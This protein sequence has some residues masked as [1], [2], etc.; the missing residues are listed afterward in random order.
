MDRL[1][2][3]HLQISGETNI[4]L[5]TQRALRVH[6]PLKALQGWHDYFT[7]VGQIPNTS[8]VNLDL[9]PQDDSDKAQHMS[10]LLSLAAES[11]TSVLTI[12]AGAE[13]SIPDLETREE[14]TI[15]IV[16]AT[17]YEFQTLRMNEEFLHLLPALKRVIVGYFGPDVPT[18][19]AETELVHHDCCPDC[20]ENR[21]SRE[22]FF[23][24]GLYHDSNKSGVAVQHP[25]DLLVALHPGFE[26]VESE[27]WRPTLDSILDSGVPTV[28]TT[29]NHQEAMLEMTIL[30][31]MG[32]HVV[33]GMEKNKWSGKVPY[34]ECFGSRYEF[35]YT[36]H[37]CLL[38]L[39][40][41]RMMQL[42]ILMVFSSSICVEETSVVLLSRHEA[43]THPSGPPILA[44]YG[45][46]ALIDPRLGGTGPFSSSS[47]LSTTSTSETSQSSFV[48]PPE[49]PQRLE[50]LAT[51][52]IDKTSDSDALTMLN[53][54]RHVYESWEVTGFTHS[55]MSD[56][57]LNT[58]I[59]EQ[60][61]SRLKLDKIVL[62]KAL[63]I[64]DELVLMEW[65]EIEG[66][67]R[68]VEKVAQITHK[69]PSHALTLHF[70]INGI[71]QVAHPTPLHSPKAILQHFM[72]LE[73]TLKY[74]LNESWQYMRVRRDGMDLGTL[75]EVRQSFA[76]WELEMRGWGV[77]KKGW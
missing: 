60:L 70:T 45:S 44:L 62:A 59:L 50:Q 17:Y 40:I 6:Q 3:H 67:Q 19:D 46:V 7:S 21:R 33:R 18:K 61:K 42:D 38:Q 2:L 15:H 43:C 25:P 71:S 56:N 30:D 53:L 74:R 16:G 10:A 13:A 5:P 64:G 72:K 8:C 51:C 65:H 47:T 32:A 26:E 49:K 1:R 41:L 4:E 9:S 11:A 66:Q 34:Q 48:W 73:P 24:R 77:V 63:D 57:G 12:L 28:F 29:Y 54:P 35:Y 58:K 68:C 76:R 69:T 20:T 36:N 23:K 39:A 37:F 75:D 52:M 14:I 22:V 31:E 27:S 55:W